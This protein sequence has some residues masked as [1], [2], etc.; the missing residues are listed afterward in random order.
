MI[1]YLE[2]YNKNRVSLNKTIKRGDHINKNEYSIAVIAIII[3]KKNEI[4]LTKRSTNKSM[5]PGLWECTAGSVQLG[6]TSKQAIIREIKEEIGL[7]IKNSEIEFQQSFIEYND[8]FDVW[9]SVVDFNLHDISLDSNEV[10]DVI[11]LHVSELKKFIDTH[12]VT[13]SLNKIL[14]ILQSINHI[15]FHDSADSIP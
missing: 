6:E 1:E 13:T 7:N 5:A 8:I 4:L 2:L 15:S 11:I 12:N 3:N 10:D 14:D 9:L